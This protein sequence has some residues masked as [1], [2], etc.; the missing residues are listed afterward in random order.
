MVDETAG[1]QP[2]KAAV[3]DKFGEIE[4]AKIFDAMHSLQQA[5]TSMAI[6]FGTTN[7]TALGIAFTTQRAGVVAL[8]SLLPLLLL[9][10]D[11]FVRGT[12]YGYYYRAFQLHRRYYSSVGES[13]LTMF[14]LYL[15]PRA[16]PR[17]E[18]L[19]DIV[20]RELLFRKLARLPWLVP[21][22]FGFGVPLLAA[23]SEVSFAWFLCMHWQ[24]KLF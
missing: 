4:I 21:T 17:I 6:F 19:S 12:L 24:W 20:D 9:V 10:L 5:R 16:A 18:A 14:R 15:G 7:L 23:I 8:A 2:P 22:T 13:F 3:L 1:A 11:S